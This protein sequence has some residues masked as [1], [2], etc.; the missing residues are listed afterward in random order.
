MIRDLGNLSN[1]FLPQ[2]GKYYCMKHRRDS[3]TQLNQVHFDV[4]TAH[5][6][7]LQTP[8][9]IGAHIARRQNT[10]RPGLHSRM[11]SKEVLGRQRG[12]RKKQANSA[13]KRQEVE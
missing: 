12:G 6:H 1:L 11:S 7:V 9:S 2:N 5:G 13:E 8:T 4:R 3:W 10:L